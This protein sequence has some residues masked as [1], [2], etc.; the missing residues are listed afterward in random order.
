MG[1]GGS[2]QP[3]RQV[4]PLDEQQTNNEEEEEETGKRNVDTVNFAI[5]H[6]IEKRI[7]IM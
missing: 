6:N 3:L 7:A 5:K 1:Q 2:K 4:I